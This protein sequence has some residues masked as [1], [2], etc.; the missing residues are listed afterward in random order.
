MRQRPPTLFRHQPRWPCKSL[1]WYLNDCPDSVWLVLFYDETPFF[2]IKQFNT[3]SHVS[4]TN[5][6]FLKRRESQP[7]IHDFN[8]NKVVF[9]HSLYRDFS[10]F[11]F[12]LQ[13][14]F[15]GI[16]Y[17]RLKQHRREGEFGDCLRKLEVGTQ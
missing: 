15:Y 6:D 5:P 1:F 16:L 17:E 3:F 4:D 13:P 12:W 2:P 10:S 7:R 14:V 9:F 11:H 8:S